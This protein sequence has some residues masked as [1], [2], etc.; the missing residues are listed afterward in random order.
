MEWE[1]GNHESCNEHVWKA[2]VKNRVQGG[3]CPFC[4]N[5]CNKR[6]CK[7][8]RPSFLN[9]DGSHKH[10]QEHM[11]RCTNCKNDKPTCEFSVCNRSK[12]GFYCWCLDCTNEK[13]S[14]QSVMMRL[15]LQRKCC[16]DCQETNDVVLEFDHINNNK[17]KSIKGKTK[18]MKGLSP[19]QLCIEIKKTDIVCITQDRPKKM[20][21]PKKQS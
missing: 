19:S 6:Y 12:D 17:F 16:Q 20:L 10:G 18:G 3:G 9:P 7:C 21:I 2:T 14:V 5:K 1:C 4:S 11:K 8:T 15:Y 13:N